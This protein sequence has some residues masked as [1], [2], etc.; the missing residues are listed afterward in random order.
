MVKKED[1]GWFWQTT[2]AWV[3]DYSAQSES[4]HCFLRGLNRTKTKRT[5]TGFLSTRKSAICGFPVLASHVQMLT[6][7]YLP[8]RLALILSRRAILRYFCALI[9]DLGVCAIE[10]KI[11]I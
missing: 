5:S 6:K 3:L 8:Y 2:V 7:I 10:S 4:V 9:R 1:R 11:R